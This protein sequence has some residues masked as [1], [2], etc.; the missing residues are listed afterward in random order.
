MGRPYFFCFSRAAESVSRL[1][2]VWKEV[3]SIIGFRKSRKE[4]SAVLHVYHF[5]HAYR[6]MLKAI[7]IVAAV[8]AMTLGV[9]SGAL[10]DEGF[11][12]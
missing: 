12:P 7:V 2:R 6:A 9:A 1:E 3:A 10:A 11:D 8:T 5:L 4:V